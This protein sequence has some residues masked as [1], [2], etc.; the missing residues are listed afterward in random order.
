MRKSLS[1]VLS[2]AVALGV[3][4]SAA[5]V[6]GQQAPKRLI[7]QDR[8]SMEK[9]GTKQALTAK[10]NGATAISVS[11]KSP[12]SLKDRKAYKTPQPKQ[13]VSPKAD[14]DGLTGYVGYASSWG[15]EEL[16]GLYNI[17][18]TP[19][20]YAEVIGGAGRFDD[21]EGKL[22]TVQDYVLLGIFH[23]ITTQVYDSETY[24]LLEQGDG[25]S[26]IVAFDMAVNPVDGMPYGCFYNDD[27]NGF[28]WGVADYT[29]FTRQAIADVP[30]QLLAV[31]IDR[32]GAGYA[33]GGDGMVYS[34]DV[35]TGELTE[36]GPMGIENKYLTSGAVD[37]KTGAFYFAQCTD[38]ECGMYEIDTTTG[39]ATPV[40]YFDGL[41]E[42]MNLEFP[43]VTCED[44]APAAPEL[45]VTTDQGELTAHWTLTAPTTLFDGTAATGDVTYVLNVNGNT[46][47]E[48]TVAYGGNVTGTYVA[49][50]NASYSFTAQLTGADGLQGPVT[51][52][53]VFIGFGKPAAPA[54]LVLSY[55]DETRRVTLAWD[56]VTTSSNGGYLDPEH[57]TYDVYD[58]QN[59]L[60]AKDLTMTTINF[61]LPVVNVLTRYQ[62]YVVAKA[63]GE[64]SEQTYSNN[65][66][67]G[68]PVPPYVVDFEDPS[69]LDYFKIIDNN[70]DGRAW[71]VKSDAGNS[72][73][74][75]TYNGTLPHDDYAITDPGV[76]LKGGQVYRVSV[77]TWAGSS[78]YVPE[79]VELVWGTEPTAEAMTNVIAGP[80]EL[81]DMTHV[82]LAGYIHAPADAIVYVG[83]HA[84]SDADM[85]NLNVDNFKVEAGLNAMAPA[86]VT[87]VVFD[88]NYTGSLEVKGHATAPAV[89]FT[90]ATV[91][92]LTKIDIYRDGKLIKTLTKVVAGEQ[93]FF[94]D[95]T[96]AT[97]GVHTYS[98]IAY[99]EYGK[100][101]QVDK[102]KYVGFNNPAA[103]TNIKMTEDPV[104]TVH[105]TWDAPA[106]DISG[107]D[108]QPDQLPEGALYYNVY[109]IENNNLVL[110]AKVTEPSFTQTLQIEG[111]EFKQYVIEAELFS[112]LSAQAYSPFEP[113]GTPYLTPWYFNF[114][115]EAFA[116]YIM[117]AST[118]GGAQVQVFASDYF[119]DL[120]G[121]N[122]DNFAGF[123][124]QYVGYYADLFTGKISL[125]NCEAPVFSFY[126]YKV[127]E[128]DANTIDV[129]VTCDGV[130]QQVLAYSLDESDAVGEWE[131]IKVDLRDYAGKN[132][133]ITMRGT[134][135]THTYILI[136]ELA[137]AEPLDYDLH[138]AGVKAPASVNVNEEFQVIATI[139]NE[140]V[141]DADNF[142][143]TFYLNGDAIETINDLSL[144]SGDSM[145]LEIDQT[146]NVMSDE[147]NEYTVQVDFAA[148][149]NED[150]NTSMPVTV[151]LIQSSL[152]SGIVGL[153]AEG[154]NGGVELTWS[155]DENLF[156]PDAV[157]EGF[158]DGED[159][160]PVDLNGWSTIDVDG[161]PVGGINGVTWDLLQT[162]Q[163]FF[164][165]DGVNGQ[166]A[167]ANNMI[168][169]SGDK[170]AGSCF[171]YDGGL[172]DDWL[173]S[174]EL[175]GGAQTISFYAN[176]FQNQYPEQIEVLVSLGGKDVDDFVPVTA[177]VTVPGT[178]SDVN[179][180]KYTAELPDGAKYFAI[181]SFGTNAFYLMVDDIEYIPAG[182]TCSLTVVGYNVYRDGVKLNAEP[183]TETKYFDNQDKS[184]NYCVTTVFDKGESVR[185]EIVSYTSGI[186][187]LTVGGAQVAVEGHN[188]VVTNAKDMEV[189]IFTV[190][191]KAIVRN[192]G[193][194]RVN[195]APAVYVVK[196]GNNNYKVIVR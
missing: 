67:L 44:N 53:N 1:L 112:K 40:Y 138:V 195:V 171:L 109:E 108:I 136:D 17:S 23:M 173:V 71:Y 98:F 105:L 133:Q 101:M 43:L 117:G 159:N 130:E 46:I 162:P 48:G 154:K 75:I 42:V 178:V 92:P 79:K 61:T 31:G 32:T 95:N 126:S 129:F 13:V 102:D 15:S 45:A 77:E 122:G 64:T 82:E 19:E 78:T 62:Y 104:G 28:V 131:K 89:D 70:A 163:G 147:V 10:V 72:W 125:E 51:K 8:P 175:Y 142:S 90:G 164:I 39:E 50:V 155:V 168:A 169:H 182:A 93:F 24:E 193:D 153:T 157:V 4:A 57:V 87:D 144:A 33:V 140:G 16:S 152:A 139:V 188:I 119:T 176:S 174:P 27:A 143:V 36:I 110:A 22:Y 120:T 187:D 21:G 166:L 172:C 114:N 86:G 167:A 111:Q 124:S 156:T 184:A 66:I 185:S 26:G 84:I 52:T 49:P 161:Q 29:T 189:A 118:A 38:N 99:N 177:P 3:T 113:V 91:A 190:D 170:F 81:Y 134:L 88:P 2:A 85:L 145:P 191:G 127:A 73:L 76:K 146:L 68:N 116:A 65:L 63:D 69:V 7:S 80:K 151:N 186:N 94:T 47:S 54:S 128:G 35:T 6:A 192:E 96:V 194:T 11:P 149:E 179:Y 56:A 123:Y 115:D 137:V 5:G 83:I 181:R 37:T 34:V 183:I 30:V 14:L 121:V 58:Y 165:V 100:G 150:N 60:I 107:N 97:A 74:S 59:N 18:E 41:L 25:D 132:V 103:V 160:D 141:K 148:D 55:N 180:T 9:V 196:V 20:R 12:F 106:S 135:Q 158:E